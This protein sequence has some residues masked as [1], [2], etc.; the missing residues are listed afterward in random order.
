[1]DVGEQLMFLATRWIQIFRGVPVQ[2]CFPSLLF[3]ISLP[4]VCEGECSREYSS[5]GSWLWLAELRP[6]SLFVCGGEHLRIFKCGAS[7]P[8]QT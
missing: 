3:T 6:S 1:M 7:I 2:W 8:S 5:A 4:K